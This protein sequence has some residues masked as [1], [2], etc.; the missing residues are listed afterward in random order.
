MCD[1]RI[2]SKV[3]NFLRQ[4]DPIASWKQ[5][6]GQ[7]GPMGKNVSVVMVLVSVRL[8]GAVLTIAFTITCVYLK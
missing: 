3:R 1:D 8:V 7:V 6:T 4:S 2:L 5:R